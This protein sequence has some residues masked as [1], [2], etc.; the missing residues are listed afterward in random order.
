MWGGAR[1]AEMKRVALVGASVLL[2]TACTYVIAVLPLCG[3]PLAPEYSCSYSIGECV[4]V[5]VREQSYYV[6]SPTFELEA[7]GYNL[8]SWPVALGFGDLMDP[9]SETRIGERIA[10]DPIGPGSALAREVHMGWNLPEEFV[11]RV[12]ENNCA[13][14]VWP[15]PCRTG[16]EQ[17]LELTVRAE[18]PTVIVGEVQVDLLMKDEG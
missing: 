10:G 16:L 11:E 18:S 3:E 6:G 1:V 9:T 13:G 7:T 2:L 14:H 4:E 8:C 5:E 12:L 17:P 15:W